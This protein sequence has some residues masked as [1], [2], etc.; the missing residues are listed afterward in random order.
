MNK[1]TL[2]ARLLVVAL[3]ITVVATMV[4]GIMRRP[5]VVQAASTHPSVAASVPRQCYRWPILSYGS[6]DGPTSG[7]VSFAQAYMNSDYLAHRFPNSPFNFHPPLAVDGIFGDHTLA[8]VKD[9][10]TRYHV[11]VD[12]VIGPITW[13]LINPGCGLG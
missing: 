11:Q 2:S 1:R 3:A 10:Q 8:A 12:G 6:T 4:Y 13:N 7:Y 9:I 5:N